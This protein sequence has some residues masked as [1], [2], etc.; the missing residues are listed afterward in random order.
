MARKSEEL[1]LDLVSE[2]LAKLYLKQ[3]MLDNALEI[4]EK[5]MLQ[6]PSNNTFFAA[7]IEKIKKLKN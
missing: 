1:K 7:Q 4:Y 2:S 6:N 3:G 5:L